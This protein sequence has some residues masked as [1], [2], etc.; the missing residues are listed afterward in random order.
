MPRPHRSDEPRRVESPARMMV[1]DEAPVEI[2]AMR[3]IQSDPNVALLTTS[4]PAQLLAVLENDT[5]VPVQEQTNGMRSDSVAPTEAEPKFEA[6]HFTMPPPNSGRTYHTMSDAPKDGT[7]LEAVSH[8]GAEFHMIWR[9][10]SRYNARES[11]WEPVGFWSNHLSRQPLKA[12]PV[13]WRMPEGFVTPGQ[14]AV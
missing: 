10:T 12:E 11:R 5:N 3:S 6:I 7:L 1:A 2:P 9:R 14:I 8:D 13:G 4:Q